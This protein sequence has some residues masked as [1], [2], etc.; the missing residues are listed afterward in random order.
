MDGTTGLIGI[1]H[2][3][4]I[5]IKN[6]IVTHNLAEVA[7]PYLGITVDKVYSEARNQGTSI[8]PPAQGTF[9]NTL[10]LIREFLNV[11]PWT[12]VNQQQFLKRRSGEFSRRSGTWWPD[13]NWSC[14]PRSWGQHRSKDEEANDR[15]I[16][17]EAEI[18]IGG[19]AGTEREA[20]IEFPALA[21]GIGHQ[22]ENR[23]E[24]AGRQIIICEMLWVFKNHHRPLN[25]ATRGLL[26]HGGLFRNLQDF[27]QYRPFSRYSI[28]RTSMVEEKTTPWYLGSWLHSVSVEAYRW[29]CVR[30]REDLTAADDRD[31]LWV[32]PL[33]IQQRKKF[34][35][36]CF[37]TN[38]LKAANFLK[39]ENKT[40][41]SVR[42]RDQRCN[43]ICNA[44]SIWNESESSE[45]RDR[46]PSDSGSSKPKDRDY[47][48]G[49][50]S[51]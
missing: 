48:Y 10:N 50:R 1:E 27:P 26:Q 9:N 11:H 28:K 30:N 4:L 33:G 2:T 8:T 25:S 40:P 6:Y 47:D 49:R 38:G 42:I 51:E 31:I 45:I 5:V 24:S 39:A 21:I 22:V 20:E 13:K 41:I 3:F 17:R 32:L 34:L 7:T 36:N 29:G 15:I 14:R 44:S 43:V 12:H 18:G 19:E 35:G 23:E 16:G 46:L 37:E